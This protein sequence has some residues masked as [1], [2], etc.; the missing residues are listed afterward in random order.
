ML[1][2]SVTSSARG[3]DD[4]VARQLRE[5]AQAERDPQLREKLWQEYCTYKKSTG[6]KQCKAKKPARSA[7]TADDD[8]DDG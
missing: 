3:D 8:E 2:T 7:P 6:G 1:A 4:I 5:A